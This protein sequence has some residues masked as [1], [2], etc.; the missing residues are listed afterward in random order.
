[1]SDSKYQLQRELND[2][3]IG[4]RAF[5]IKAAGGGRDG[6]ESGGIT[7]AR[8]RLSEVGVVQ[9][10]EK[11]R[12]ELQVDTF[13]DSEVPVDPRIDAFVPG[14]AEAVAA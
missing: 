11:L 9:D 13:F 10:I 6:S 3:W 14:S 7:E 12:A 5:A 1:M 4:S 8:V 2:P